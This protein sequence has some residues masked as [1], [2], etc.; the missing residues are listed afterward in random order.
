MWYARNILRTS[1]TKS[2]FPST[3]AHATSCILKMEITH[4]KSMKYFKHVFRCASSLSVI[5]SVLI[6]TKNYF[7]KNTVSHR[8]KSITMKDQHCKPGRILFHLSTW[9]RHEKLLNGA[10]C[11]CASSKSKE[12]WE[13][14]IIVNL[15]SSIDKSTVQLFSNR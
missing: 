8:A 12:L 13:A 10:S 2:N 3:F 7:E 11:G 5:F 14:S 4:V 6:L 1:G 9:D 15:V